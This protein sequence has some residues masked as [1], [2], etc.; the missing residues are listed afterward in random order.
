MVVLTST[1]FE[2]IEQNAEDEL[3]FVIAHEL[4][5]I[6][7][8]HISKQLIILPALWIPGLTQAY[9]RACEYTCDRYASYYTGNTEAANNCLTIIGIGKT[10]FQYVNRE[11]YLKQA[12]ESSP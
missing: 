1:M 10:L 7:R 4:A 11:A 8:R 9:S 3:T 12:D 6:K 5:H 2:L